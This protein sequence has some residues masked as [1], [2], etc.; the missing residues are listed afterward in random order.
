MVEAL[1]TAR[2]RVV[3]LTG[4]TT[5]TEDILKLV[6]SI[7]YKETASGIIWCAR[8]PPKTP[9]AYGLREICPARAGNRRFRLLSA[10]RAHTKAPYKID[11]HR[12][13][14]RVLDRPWAARTVLKAPRGRRTARRGLIRKGAGS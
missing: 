5:D 13:T 11:F 6:D 9:A 12:K 3:L 10:L 1:H 7:N 2:V 4:H 14:L 8:A